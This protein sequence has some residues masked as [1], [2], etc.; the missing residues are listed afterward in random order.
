MD[1]DMVA[2]RNANRF[3]DLLTTVPGIRVVNGGQG[4]VGLVSTRN[5]GG[6]SCVTVWM[7]GAEWK[8]LD[9]GDLDSFV[10]PGEVSAIET[11]P[12]SN[13]PA[14]FT[15]IGSNC[16]AVVV[17]TKLRVETRKK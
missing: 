12:G 10:R 9:A 1:P 5:A 17:W 13:V 4:Q 14:Q 16:A 15:T 7:D 2:H 8:Q 3:T 6:N 11:Y